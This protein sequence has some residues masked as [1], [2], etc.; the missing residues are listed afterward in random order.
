MSGILAI[1]PKRRRDLGGGFEVGRV[2]PWKHPRT[3][4]PFVFF[5]HIGPT[6][7]PPALPR[8]VDVRPHPHVGLAT[9]T[10]LFA[11][12]IVH[13]DSLGF[14][15]VIRPGEVNWMTAGCGITH[16][17]RFDT[18]R[19]HGGPIHGIQAWVALPDT[20]EEIEPSFAHLDMN[21]LP[22]CE[23]PD[24]QIRIIAGEAFNRRSPVQIHSPL[25]Y[26]H[27]ELA[28][29]T[30]VRLPDGYTERAAFVAAGIAEAAGK[31]LEAGQM[32]VFTP[33]AAVEIHA[34]DTTTLML[35]GGEPLGERHIEWNFVS[36]RMERIE[37]AKLD[38]REGRFKLPVGDDREFIPLPEK[39][40][41]VPEPMS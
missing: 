38:W 19:E 22:A 40:P 4:G 23:A 32:A 20:H 28:P 18:M 16:S 15:Q 34:R 6:A 35:L 3:V 1:I 14:H 12:E 13:R 31:T 33:G 41:P 36:S 29:Q 11:G 2:L 9:I 26:A 25:F 17:E 37:K 27:A 39:S 7:F 8:S 5:D 21:A 30:S 24:V 10:Y